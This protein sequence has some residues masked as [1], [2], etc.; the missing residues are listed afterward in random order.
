MIVGSN[1]IANM[2]LGSAPRG[3]NKVCNDNQSSSTQG[4][5]MKKTAVALLSLLGL[6]VIVKLV[7]DQI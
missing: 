4:V 5:P 1:T 7:R 3:K 6:A 2:V